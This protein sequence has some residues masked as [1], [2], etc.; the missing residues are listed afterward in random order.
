MI[1]GVAMGKWVLVVDDDEDVRNSVV[2]VLQGAGYTATG[3]TGGAAALLAMGTGA[4]APA[5]VLSDIVMREMD[6]R[7]LLARSRELL[8]AL[9]PPFIFMT[10][11]ATELVD[12][13]APVL[14]KPYDLEQLLEAV[15]HHC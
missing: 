6:G 15:A 14:T 9:V 5:L 3:A 12:A 7:E 11:L 4:P 10:G 8:G 1:R 2:E 13:A